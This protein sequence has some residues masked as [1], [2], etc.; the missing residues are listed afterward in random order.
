MSREVKARLKLFNP[1]EENGYTYGRNSDK[2]KDRR[3]RRSAA[4]HARRPKYDHIWM[5]EGTG[6]SIIE[7]EE[8]LF[9]FECFVKT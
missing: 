9:E 1:Q 7:I 2:A 6:L 8:L 4:V 3:G 5:M